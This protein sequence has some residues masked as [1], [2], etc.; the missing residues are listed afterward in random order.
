MSMVRVKITPTEFTKTKPN[1]N[2]I[3][4]AHAFLTLLSKKKKK[5]KKELVLM[6][7]PPGN[8]RLD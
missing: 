4:F 7:P 8:R 1:Q 2:P 6:L 3:T 5:K